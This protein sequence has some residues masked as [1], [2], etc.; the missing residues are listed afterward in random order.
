MVNSWHFLADETR[1]LLHEF[2]TKNSGRPHGEKMHA[3]WRDHSGS[4]FALRIL[5]HATYPVAKQIAAGEVSSSQRVVAWGD[6]CMH[7]DR[8]PDCNGR[9]APRSTGGGGTT[10]AGDY[11]LHYSAAA[12]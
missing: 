4:Y 6:G 9:H 12:G 7:H 8:M 2:C 1:G 5:R 11:C 3:V 10:T